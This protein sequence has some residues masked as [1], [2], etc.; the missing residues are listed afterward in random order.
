[1]K[2]ENNTS[3]SKVKQEESG[4]NNI[5]IVRVM[6]FMAVVGWSIEKGLT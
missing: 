6:L 3:S 2:D 1:M 4:V 5:S